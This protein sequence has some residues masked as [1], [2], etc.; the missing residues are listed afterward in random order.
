MPGFT[1]HY[2]FGLVAYKQMTDSKLKRTIKKNHKAYALGLQ[3]PDV[4]FYYMPSYFMHHENLGV[5]AHDTKPGAFF[6]NL[7]QS[8]RLFEQEDDKAQIADA[9]IC[10]F[11]GHY[12]LD[13]IVHPYVYA[14]T[15][16]NPK[17]KPKN[18]EYFGKH[19]YLETELDIE[20]LRKY[21]K[22]KPTDFSQSNT[23]RLSALQRQV[24]AT[25][26]TYAYRK[27][28]HVFANPYT[29]KQAMLW[30]RMGTKLT[31]DPSGQ[32]KVLVRFVER[33]L[34]KRAFISP[35]LASNRYRFVPDPLNEAHRTWIHPWTRVSSAQTFMDLFENACGLFEKRL[36]LYQQLEA[37]NFEES[38]K[39][40][41]LSAYGNCSFL[42]GE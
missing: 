19:A 23:I 5:L 34:M 41:L 17:V 37:S 31:N 29:M 42:S 20:L 1:T 36:T 11:M 39:E 14:F 8:R 25:M 33:I 30:M 16:Y 35:M 24:V 26:L 27:T 6:E 3:G 9:Y 10:G 12:T 15:G 21:K 32:K 38:Q 22:M 4:F 2:L 18:S 7:L 28:Y 40:A 13:C